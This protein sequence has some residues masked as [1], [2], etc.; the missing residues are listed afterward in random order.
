MR[1]T[2][3]SKGEAKVGNETS[4]FYQSYATYKRYETPQVGRKQI[5]RF[6]AEVWQPA[7]FDTQCQVLELGC[8]TGAFL[9]Y[10]KTKGVTRIV[11]VD[12]DPTLARVV[13]ESVRDCFHCADLW[14]ALADESLGSFDR[15]ALFDVLEHFTADDA[16]RLLQT[17][18]K[19]LRPQARLILKVPNAA[20]PW[21][22]QYQFGDLTHRTA[23]TPLSLRQLA[24]AAGFD[25]VSVY[26]QR[27]GSR[28]RMLT[29]ALVHRFLSWALLTP[30][31]FWSANMYAVLVPR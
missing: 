15:V 30:P 10:L 14:T 3:T 9:D 6:D 26:P 4:D 13:P 28:R 12:H 20:C 22:L 2:Q 31:E 11:G 17:L 25:A 1:Y 23:F 19:R 16:L 7:Q 8:G 24:D 21:A 27:Q 18:K 5:A 29:D